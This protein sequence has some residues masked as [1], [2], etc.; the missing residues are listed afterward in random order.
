MNKILKRILIGL[1]TL[2]IVAFL[3][4]LYFIPPF[5]L[6]P[7]E[8]FIRPTLEAGPPLDHITDPAKRAIAERGKYIV[9]ALGCSDCHTPHGE[10]GPD[11]SRYMSGGILLAAAGEGTFISRNLTPD[12]ETGIGKRTDEEVKRVLRSGVFHT[13]RKV[14]HRA[15][16]WGSF[17]N[18]SDE[19]LY[20]IILYLRQLHPVR[21]QIPDPSPEVTVQTMEKVEVFLPGDFGKQ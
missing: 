1:G 6:V 17:S 13:G 5:T 16:P 18:M 21:N 3:A 19:D 15:M 20:A 11:L 4:F 14:N 10:Q 7:Q 2:V 12:E 8:E 9:T